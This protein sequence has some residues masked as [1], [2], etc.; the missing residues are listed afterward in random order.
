MSVEKRMEDMIQMLNDSMKDAAKHGN[1][2]KAAG[3]RVRKVLQA[4]AIECKEL[5][6]QVQAERSAE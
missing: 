4:V 1:G 5:R 6:K 3:T 2:N